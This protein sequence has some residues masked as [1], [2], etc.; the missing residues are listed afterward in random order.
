MI[1]EE[2]MDKHP[3][4]NSKTIFEKEN[5]IDESIVKKR[6][7]WRLIVLMMYSEDQF[8]MKQSEDRVILQQM[9]EFHRDSMKKISVDS[10]RIRS[11]FHIVFS[12][13]FR[14]FL[15]K[16]FLIKS[17]WFSSCCIDV[18]IFFGTFFDRDDIFRFFFFFF[19][20]YL[21]EIFF[22]FFFRR[23]AS[24]QSHFNKRFPFEIKFNLK[25]KKKFYLTKNFFVLFLKIKF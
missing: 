14:F 24:G 25:K 23:L 2:S 4:I 5:R 20:F 19:L 22:D 15:W 3:K 8:E 7:T 16:T 10:K 17:E 18:E 11:D 9:N 12:I 21:K 1:V 6:F 13:W